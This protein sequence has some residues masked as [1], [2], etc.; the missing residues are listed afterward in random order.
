M[1]NWLFV[2]AL[3]SACGIQD[4]EV[5]RGSAEERARVIVWHEVL[6]SNWHAPKITWTYETCP[7]TPTDPRTAVITYALDGS[8]TCYSG[9]FWGPFWEGAVAWRGSFSESAYVHELLHAVLWQDGTEDREH[10]KEIWAR[11][12]EINDRLREE[13]L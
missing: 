7:N 1:R 4:P 2:V 6:A 8:V 5:Q 10:K 9:L 11:E 3:L 13:G 12:N